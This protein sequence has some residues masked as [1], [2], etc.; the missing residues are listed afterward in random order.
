MKTYT[1]ALSQE[2]KDYNRAMAKVNV[3]GSTLDSLNSGDYTIVLTT[4]TWHIESR[5][6]FSKN[7][8]SVETENITARQYACYI[9]SIGFFGD[10]VGMGY[11]PVGYIP[12][13]LTC[14]SPNRD[15]KIERTFSITPDTPPW[16]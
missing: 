16:D 15:I 8:Q 6:N 5:K 13:N 3:Y 12:T 2:F 11:T 7:P 4:R 1:N 10:R 14:K 9:T